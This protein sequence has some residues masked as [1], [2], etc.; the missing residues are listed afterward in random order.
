MLLTRRF[1]TIGGS[2][3]AYI[4]KYGKQPVVFVHGFFTSCLLWSKIFKCA[5]NDDTLHLLALDMEGFG[6]TFAPG[7]MDMGFERQTEFLAQFLMTKCGM[8]PVSLVTHAHGAIAALMLAIQKPGLVSDLML[9]SPVFSDVF[10]D[11]LSRPFL[12]TSRFRFAWETLFRSGFAHAHVERYLRSNFVQ[13][14]SEIME[15][16][17]DFWRPF[18]NSASARQRLRRVFE[19]TDSRLVQAFCRHLDRIKVP[20]RVVIG[21]IDQRAGSVRAVSW[22]NRFA[23]GKSFVIN[24]AGCFV[25]L[26][27]PEDV[28]ALLHTH[29]M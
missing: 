22:A 4:E 16:I 21:R 3:V 18:A 24:H 19:E 1:E 27:N 5:S 8:R 28:L 14:D 9:I 11:A 29:E 6:D 25:P 20:V 7:H 2:R 17:D 10:P 15:I 23:S 12:W 26:E 13:A